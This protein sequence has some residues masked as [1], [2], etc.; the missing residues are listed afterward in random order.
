MDTT[1]QLDK[2]IN[3]CLSP[4]CGQDRVGRASIGIVQYIC[5][6]ESLGQDDVN[7]IKLYSN[8][9]SNTLLLARYESL[10][11]NFRALLDKHGPFDLLPCHSS[12]SWE[13]EKSSIEGEMT[14]T[15]NSPST[16]CDT[17]NGMGVMWV[18]GPTRQPPDEMES[19]ICS[20]CLGTGT[21]A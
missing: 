2:F 9:I 12:L 5:S 1:T 20:T 11:C 19:E 15:R 18:L 8:M 21:E 17:C 6:R 7:W 10:G 3:A 14:T 13:K 16:A 4:P